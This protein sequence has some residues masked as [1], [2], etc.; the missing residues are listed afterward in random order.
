LEDEMDK[1]IEKNDNKNN[2]KSKT[3]WITIVNY[4]AMSAGEQKFFH[5]F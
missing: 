2:K 5:T 3:M 4:S 1:K